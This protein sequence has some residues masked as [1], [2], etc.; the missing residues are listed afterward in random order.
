ML[1]HDPTYLGKISSVSGS[2]VTVDLARS[3]DSGISLVEGH[4]YRIGQVGSFVR[5][6]QGYQDLYGIVAEIGATSP[7]N[8]DGPTGRWLKA[9]LLGEALGGSFQRGISY[10]PNVDDHVHLATETDL[11]K[12]YRS[13]IK[14]QVKIGTLSSSESISAKL[15]LNELVTRHSAVL[16]S[17]GAGKS[18]TIASILRSVV[19]GAGENPTG[20]Y[21]SARIL[22]LDLHGEYSKALS[23]VADVFSVHPTDQ[24]RQL[25]IPYWALEGRDLIQTLCGNLDEKRELAF[26]DKIF[27]LKLKSQEENDFEGVDVTTLTVDT[28][29]PFS[30]K[31]LWY[32][33]IDFEISTFKGPQRDEPALLD[34]GD[35]ETLLQPKYEPHAMGSAGPFLNQQAK[36]IRR[37]LDSIRSRLLDRRYDFLL[38][39]GPWEPALDGAV[40]SD[41]DELLSQWLGGQK[42]ISILDL[43]S[44]PSTVLGHLVGSILKTIFEAVYW[45][46]NH[47]EG[48]IER[49]LLV[50][51][52]EA[53]RYLSGDKET[54]ATKTVQRI[55]KEGRKYGVGAML[56]SQRPS[57]VD[58]TILSQCGT[59]VSLRMGNPRD[60]SRIK[61]A[62]PDNLSGLLDVLPVLRTGEAIIVGEAAQL[63]MRCRVNLPKEE[64]R[65]RSSDPD[66]HSAW[67]KADKAGE[68]YS[69]LVKTW[70]A[71]GNIETE[72]QGV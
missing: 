51:M 69:R 72:K 35:A 12:I 24:E 18:T 42:P 46:K 23:D 39:P 62:L 68:D 9:Q 67:S 60:R 2:S 5:I 48:G 10:F 1:E 56:V 32:E 45:G 29:I 40:E 14:G 43:S 70:R 50:V 17:T 22:L 49:P 37:Q 58:E 31:K 30:I 27:E 38:S 65:P 34:E 6:P 7:D 8:E 63:P 55:A 33:L 54:L 19:G 26:T 25:R 44:V 41:L 11:S 15:S 64:H 61:G 66:V 28:P 21:D 59:F 16:G 47:A 3:V 53:H 36:G 71:Q 57:E 20:E 4:A 13:E 52:E